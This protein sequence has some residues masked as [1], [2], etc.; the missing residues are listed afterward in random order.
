MSAGQSENHEFLISAV[1][2]VYNVERYLPAFLRSLET[3][4]F[5]VENV[6]LILVDDGSTDN[7]LAVLHEW[8]ASR[9]GHVEVLTQPNA[10]VAEARN[11]GL[12]RVRG[13]WVTFTDPDDVLEPDYFSEVAKFIGLY[14]D[15]QREDPVNL[16]AAHQMRLMEDGEIRDNHPQRRK[17]GLGSRIVNLHADPIIQLSVNSSFMRTEFVR[18]HGLRFDDRVRPNFE[19]GHFIAKYMLATKSN[20]MG[21]MASAKYLYRVR[22]DGTSLIEKS[23]R[24]REKYTN[25][26]EYGYLDALETAQAQLGSIPRWLQNT[27]LYDLFWYYKE[28]LA[29]QSLSASAPVEVLP[30]FHEL[31]QRIRSLL[32]DDAIRSFDLMWV[33]FPVREAFRRGYEPAPIRHDYVRLSGVDEG[34][35][36]VKISYWFSGNLPTEHFEVDGVEASAQHETVRDYEFYGRVLIRERHI[37]LARGLRTKI[38]LDGVMMRVAR[39]DDLGHPEGLSNRQIN[40][41]IMRQRRHVSARYAPDED[42]LLAHAKG[43]ARASL[44]R[45]RVAVGKTNLYDEALE[46]ALRSR[47]TRRKYLHAWAFMDRDTDAND[48]AEH[49]YRWVREN[50][51]EINAWFVLKRDSND[52]DRL[53]REGFRLVAHGT[54]EWKLL[55]LHADHLASS[56]ADVYVTQ[57]LPQRRYG[58][59]RFKYTFLQHG[60]IHN[61]LSR[62]LSWKQ[63]DVLVTTTPAEYRAIAGPGPYSFSSH[64]VALTGLPRHDSLLAKRRAVGAADRDIILVM[65]TWRQNLLGERV[66]GSNERKK[67]ANFRNSEYAEQYRALLGS[68]RL[69]ALARES[70]KTL[71]FM[72]HP[73]MRVYLAEFDLPDHVRLLDF[74]K[75]GVQDVLARTAAFVT[76]YSSLAF[77]AAFLDIPLAY[78]QFDKEAFFDGQHV[79]RPGY[80]DY[81]AHGF[82]PV[83]RGVDDVIDALTHLSNEA[84]ESPVEYR[85]RTAETFTTR[86]GRSSERVV[87]AM[88]ALGD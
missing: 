7:G 59:S 18:E 5:G 39:G 19:D 88:R 65:P 72:P 23:F 21:L 85:Q 73:N 24:L 55:M 15:A 30:R 41:L 40:P 66:E 67:L 1:V 43:R 4:T 84:Y 52:W 38:I 47:S 80:F 87:D 32:D 61:D 44:R 45:A 37:W 22:G 70:G 31:A 69:E 20:H 6:Q 79:G 27:V 57:P 64:E 82:G 83:V 56:H 46:F 62:W 77:D 63:I 74:S 34:R 16:L 51:P 48:N 49:L 36:L 8:A 58:R 53:E 78:F 28:Q 71:A 81:D 50:R 68:P 9:P 3:Q 13:E 26:L 17:F 29:V 11:T 2:A 35:Q 60:V 14:G 42:G 12:E 10:W 25:V 75:D 33:D 76:D 54:W 86:D